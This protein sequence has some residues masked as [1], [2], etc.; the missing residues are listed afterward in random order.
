MILIAGAV[1]WRS[2]V[3]SN[4]ADVV[5]GP[6]D[7]V[8]IVAPT[9]DVAA[10]QPIVLTWRAAPRAVRYDIEVIASGGGLIYGTGV[11]DTATA[12]P[13][14]FL[15]PGVEYRWRV[16]AELTDG[17]RVGSAAQAFRVRAP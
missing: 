3:L 9:G 11:T 1:V 10:D 17:R 6:R 12:V 4:G 15:K 14:T 16:T 7:G 2:G 8:S 13:A 5:R